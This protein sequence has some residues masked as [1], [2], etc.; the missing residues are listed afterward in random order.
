MNGEKKS[1]VVPFAPDL[2]PL[3]RVF[4]ERYWNRPQSEAYYD[5]R[6]V[7]PQAFGRMFLVVQEDECLGVLSALRKPYRL[8]GQP[9]TLLEV[10]DWHALPGQRGS[11]VGIR[12]MRAMMRQPER[13]VSIGG[14]AD[15]QATLPLMGWQPIGSA[16]RYELPLSGDLLGSRL[17]QRTRLPAVVTRLAAG[18]LSAVHFRPRRRAVPAG[19]HVAVALE[20]G[21]EIRD[22]YQGETGFGFVMEPE[23]DVLRWVARGRWS[24][25][26]EFLT[27]TLGGKPRGWAMTRTHRT[28]QGIQ[29][30]LVE[31]FAPRPDLALYTWM[32][33][34]AATRLMKAAPYR[35]RVRAS[36][37]I[38]QAALV[39][40]RFR[41]VVPDIPIHSWPKLEGEGPAP[42][43]VTY[44][45]TDGPLLPYEADPQDSRPESAGTRVAEGTDEP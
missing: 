16:R 21:E 14:T 13:V 9:A 11:G 10:F 42:L 36:C 24:G 22:L 37:P 40:N 8:R 44:N 26:Y 4:S 38:L 29:G 39:A 34:E 3:V 7:Q 2:L 32:V 5:W 28:D 18:A 43:H 45:H 25:H 41:K 17:R 20:P 33:S 6:Y 12:L 19:G 35:L 23:F 30:T 15:V 27:F 31:V 1:S